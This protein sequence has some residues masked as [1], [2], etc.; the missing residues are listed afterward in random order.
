MG[1]QL[2]PTQ[3]ERIELF[4]SFRPFRNYKQ[5]MTTRYLIESM[6]GYCLASDECSDVLRLRSRRNRDNSS[7]FSTALSSLVLGSSA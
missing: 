7:F 6:D 3:L 2:A 4:Y 5:A 1:H